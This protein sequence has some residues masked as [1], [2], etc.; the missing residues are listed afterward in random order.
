MWKIL[1]IKIIEHHGQS[2]NVI[3]QS[4]AADADAG[5]RGH[6]DTET[7]GYGDTGK[8]LDR[9]CRIYRIV[10]ST[11]T[12][13]RRYGLI[14]SA[15]AVIRV[16]AGTVNCIIPCMADYTM[17][18]VDELRKILGEMKNAG[19]IH[20]ALLYGSFAKGAQ[21]VRSD[22]DL[23]VYLNA[24]TPEEELD[25]ID[26]ILMS[27][28]RDVSILRLDDQDESPFVVQEALKGIHLVDPDLERLYEVSHRVLHE[29]ETIRFRREIKL[30]RQD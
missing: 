11:W 13:K 9:I 19:K 15:C 27:V 3:F 18:S 23:A 14:W 5:T 28:D 16:H 1:H 17:E 7:R 20:L 30:F 24:A 25:L 26:R 6:G 22:I 21:H 29:C 8:S 2:L 10:K 4:E 12:M